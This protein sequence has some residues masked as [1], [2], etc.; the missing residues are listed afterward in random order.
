MTV[1][2]L[3]QTGQPASTP[4]PSSTDDRMVVPRAV[5]SWPDPTSNGAAEL[6]TDATESRNNGQIH[7][8]GA[9][10]RYCDEGSTRGDH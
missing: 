3:A 7:R 8:P 2:A 4:G 6:R 1:S 5:N 9:R 10:D